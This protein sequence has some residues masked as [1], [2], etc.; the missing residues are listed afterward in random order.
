MLKLMYI[1]NSPEVAL[2]A[3]KYGIDRIWI[4]LETL[5][6]E[7]RQ[8]GM[9]TVKSNHTISD[10]KKIAPLLKKSDMLVRINPINKDSKKEINDVIAAGAQL[11]MLPMWKSVDD[12][13]TFLSYV[14]HRVKTILLLETKEAVDC[15]DDVLKLKGIDEIHIG[16]NDLH[17]SYGLTFMFELLS[18]GV[19]ENICNKI[20][21]ANIPYGIGGIAKLGYGDLPAEKVIIEHY[22]LGSTRAILSRSFCNTALITDINEIEQTF[23]DNM[24]HLREYEEKVS[25]MSDKEINKNT[26]E[27]KQIVNNIVNKKNTIINKEKMDVLKEKCGDSFYVLDTK[28]FR[29]NFIELKS[30]IEKYYPKFNIAY[31]YKTNYIPKLCRIIN[32]LNGYAE[33]VSEMELQL[34]LKVGVEPNRI[35][36]NGPIKNSDYLSEYACK[37]VTVNIDNYE[38]AILLDNISKKSSK[39][40]NVGIRCNFDVDDGVISRFGLDTNSEDFSKVLSI[41]NNNKKLYLINLQCHFAKRQLD[42]WPNRAKKMIE[43]IEKLKVIPERIDLGGG[44]YGNMDNRLKEQF[45]SAIPS[46]QEYALSFAPILH[47]FFEKKG[48][49]PELIIEP[50]SALV[51]DSMKFVCTVNNIKNIRGKYFASVTGSQKNISMTGVNPP[52]DIIKYNND[53]K[54]YKDL[55]IVGYTC[56]EGDVLFKNYSGKLS[57][58]DVIVISNCGSYSIVMKPPFILPNFYIVE[59]SNNEIEIIKNKESFDYIFETYNF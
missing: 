11:V 25:K 1:T 14:N 24:K 54:E 59:M 51:G 33:V 2:I 3:E 45:S 21:K 49:Y 58:G 20:K 40:I 44:L 29:S 55:D 8:N 41:I 7:K 56:I 22:R 37:G 47:D 50:G 30:A 34:A 43:L 23:K 12:V 46:Y 53:S 52:I 36:W 5:G 9:N 10:I 38:E 6:K 57:V 4:D 31:S 19:V 13:E 32:E 26:K 18:N 39:K 48:V 27:V 15:L 42:Y 17:L 35:I 16:L 28:Q